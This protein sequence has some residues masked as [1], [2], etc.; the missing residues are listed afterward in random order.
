MKSPFLLVFITFFSWIV[1]AQ[2]PKNIVSKDF[3]VS[4]GES[5]GDLKITVKSAGR[6]LSKKEQAA[7]KRFA[8]I[9]SG[10]EKAG[11]SINKILVKNLLDGLAETA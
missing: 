10:N 1:F 6:E 3:S 9:L 7:V 8:L 5:N 11:S 2:M 4:T